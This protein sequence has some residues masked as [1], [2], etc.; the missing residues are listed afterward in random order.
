MKKQRKGHGRRR[1]EPPD[2]LLEVKI[3]PGAFELLAGCPGHDFVA[4]SKGKK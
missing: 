3:P 1:S 4:N 2:G